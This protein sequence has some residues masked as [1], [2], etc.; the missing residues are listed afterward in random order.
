[1]LANKKPGAMAGLVGVGNSPASQIR[2]DDTTVFI[3]S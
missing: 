3:T 1:V 2:A